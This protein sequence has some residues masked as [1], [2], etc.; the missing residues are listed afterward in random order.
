MGFIE[1]M[2]TDKRP[3]EECVARY[4]EKIEKDTKKAVKE[5]AKGFLKEKD[6]KSEAAF[7]VIDTSGDG[8]IQ[9]EEFCAAFDPSSTKNMEMKR[10]L[11]VADVEITMKIQAAVTEPT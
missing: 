7:K 11:G 9:L 1:M 10:A 8:S 3:P 2:P 4:L 6:V 5:I